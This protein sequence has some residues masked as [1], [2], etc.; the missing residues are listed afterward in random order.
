[1]SIRIALIDDDP[2]IL[3]ALRLFLLLNGLEVRCFETATLFLTALT[4]G[5]AVDCIVS[6]VRLPGCSGLELQRELNARDIGVPLILITGHGNVAMAVTAMK[7]GAHDFI[8]KPF[9]EKQ[10]LESI[11]GAVNENNRTMFEGGDK[12]QISSRLA[13][14]TDRQRE[15]LGLAVNGLTN[16]DIAAQLN[17]SVRTVEHHRA[18]VMERTGAKNLAHLI[19]LMR[20]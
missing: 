16:K 4:E 5:M 1:M 18:W 11:Q 12:E 19:R 17:I 15:V 6:D 7:A 2:G 9:L 8:E 13:E 3:D 20:L 10:L 14:L